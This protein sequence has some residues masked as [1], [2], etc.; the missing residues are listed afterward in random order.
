[1]E[2]QLDHFV[3]PWPYESPYEAAAG[4][5]G[6]GTLTALRR[7][8]VP[9]AVGDV[10]VRAIWRDCTVP[11]LRWLVEQAAPVGGVKKEAAMVEAVLCGTL[12]SKDAEW[13]RGL[14]AVQD[15]EQG[16]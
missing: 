10:V 6:R 9:W 1:M 14:A 7:L 3:I 5:G 11:V 15:D 12:M 16:A 13:F 4:N 2:Q 8:R